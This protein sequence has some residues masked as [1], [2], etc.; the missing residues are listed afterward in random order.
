MT[1][2]AALAQP[3]AP[4]RVPT[5][6]AFYAF[7]A[8]YVVVGFQLLKPGPLAEFMQD[9]ELKGSMRSMRTKR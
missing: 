3:H 4:C 9:A 5:F 6:Y 1:V 2:T 8:F 7:Y